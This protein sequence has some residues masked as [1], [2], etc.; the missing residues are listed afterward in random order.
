MAPTKSYIHKLNVVR[1][2]TLLDKEKNIKQ[3][4]LLNEQLAQEHA[5]LVEAVRRE[6]AAPKATTMVARVNDA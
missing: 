2:E 4:Q 5:L 1:F 6:T 3:R